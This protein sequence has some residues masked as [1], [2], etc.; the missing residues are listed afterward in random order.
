MTAE[1]LFADT[2]RSYSAFVFSGAIANMAAVDLFAD[3][4][5]SYSVLFSAGR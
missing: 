2:V 5:R 3:A 4:V 1:D